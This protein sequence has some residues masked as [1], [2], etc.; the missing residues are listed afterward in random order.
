SVRWIDEEYH[1]QARNV[2]RERF[3]DLASAPLIE[4]RSCHYEISATSNFIVDHYPGLENVWI[5]GGGSAEGF[6]FG[7]MIGPYIAG[8]VTGSE[9]DPDLIGTFSLRALS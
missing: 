5:A 4:T 9:T 7:P 2:L 6:K 1:E 8:R 3:P